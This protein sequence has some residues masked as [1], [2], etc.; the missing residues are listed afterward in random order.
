MP[1]HYPQESHVRRHGPRG[2][3]DYRSFKPWLRDEF[4]FR[5]VYCLWRENWCA[6]GEDSF[7]VEHLLSRVA[8]PERV[9]DYDN[10]LYACCRCNSLKQEGDVPVDP[11]REGWSQHVEVG[12]DG[13]VQ[14]LT[15]VGA[16][17]IEVCRLNRPLL[18]NARRMIME[19]LEMLAASTSDKARRLLQHYLAFPENLPDLSNLQ[20]PEGNERPEGIADSYFERRRR[21]QLP[22]SY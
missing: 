10:L 20:P 11:C 7:S 19:I 13:L 14:A 2:Y 1:L 12:P 6:D 8:H 15:P 4:D 3:R 21:G 9:C 5:C 18:V 22:E 16:D 17:L